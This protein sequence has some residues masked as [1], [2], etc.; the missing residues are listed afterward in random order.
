VDGAGNATEVRHAVQDGES[1][2]AS[3]L[4]KEL[5]IAGEDPGFHEAL[6]QAI[7]ITDMLG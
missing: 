2:E 6:T 1:A 4:V 3:L 5:S 7:A